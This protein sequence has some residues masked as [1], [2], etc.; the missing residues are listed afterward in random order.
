VRYWQ[1]KTFKRRPLV[2]LVIASYVVDD[3]RRI[4]AQLSLLYCLRAQTYRNWQAVVVH[5]GP[6]GGRLDRVRKAMADDERI[7]VVAA[8]ERKQC[9]GH[10][11]RLWAVKKCTTGEYVGMANED[12]WYAPVY[13]EALLHELVN[14][15]G[16]FA[17]CDMVHSHKEW[18]PLETRPVRGRIDVGG[19]IAARVLV[20]NTPWTDM[21]F[22][23]D[24]TYIQALTGKARN[25]RKVKAHLFV[26]N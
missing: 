1:P 26:H 6:D 10:P 13:L 12:N 11:W 17:Y 15:G 19:W 5:D 2:S 7:R 20:T 18:K 4:D 14:L 24:A 25:I 23:G 9:F 16:D 22:A 21:D 8:P 3:P